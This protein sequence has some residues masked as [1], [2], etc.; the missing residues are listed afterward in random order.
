MV[1]AIIPAFNEENTVP[2]VVRAAKSSPLIGEVIVVDDGSG[3][4][5]AA[6]ARA[7]GAKVVMLPKNVGKADAMQEGVAV[8]HGEYLLFIDADL[9]GLEAA[10]LESLL[11]PVMSGKFGM[12]IGIWSRKQWWLNRILRFLPL[13]SGTRAMTREVWN[14]VPS[15]YKERFQIEIALNYFCRYRA[16]RRLGFRLISQVRHIIKEKKY[17]FWGGSWRRVRMMADIT[18]I[19]YRLYFW[20]AMNGEK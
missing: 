3:D 19:F 10:H 14:A 11:K 17:G 9:E 5:T 2:L 15:E 8:A 18:L 4:S 1:S 12:Y 6:A 7:A 20:R 13:L 16:H